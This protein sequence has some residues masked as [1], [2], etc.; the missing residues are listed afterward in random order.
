MRS[1]SAIS[2]LSAVQTMVEYG[3]G[4]KDWDDLADEVDRRCARAVDAV[5][6]GLPPAQSAA[7]M[8]AYLHAVFRFPRDNYDALLA[9][10]REAVD[11]GLTAK[12]MY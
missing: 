5:I 4:S 8:H 11:N 10:A 6:R 12:G 7:L 1:R 9:A 3:C 2:S